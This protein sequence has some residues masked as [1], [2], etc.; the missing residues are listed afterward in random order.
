[1][2]KPFTSPD[3]EV[4]ELDK[5]FFSQAK[6]GR[7]HLP[8]AAK[9]RRVNLMLD[10]DVAARLHEVGNSSAFVNGLL[11]EKLGI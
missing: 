8:E 6:R 10:P 1:M 11:R 9:K 5:S 2:P 3:G 4:R 7:P